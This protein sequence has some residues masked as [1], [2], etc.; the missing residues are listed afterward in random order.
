M[1]RVVVKSYD[2]HQRDAKR[3]ICTRCQKPYDV[4]RAEL[5]KTFVCVP[6]AS[7][8]SMRSP[9]L[10]MIDASGEWWARED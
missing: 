3:L 6:C 7:K 4:T 1:D 10:G 2:E 5:I 9:D 8:A